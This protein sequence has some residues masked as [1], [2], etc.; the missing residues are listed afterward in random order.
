MLAEVVFTEWCRLPPYFPVAASF[1]GLRYFLSDQ[2][3][4]ER[5]VCTRSSEHVPLCYL[6]GRL[7]V[8]VLALSIR[9]LRQI[10]IAQMILMTDLG[11]EPTADNTPA[12]AALGFWRFP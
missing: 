1:L 8:T 6:D 9:R 10:K 4:W 11:I 7:A 3:K 2:G 12:V 5:P